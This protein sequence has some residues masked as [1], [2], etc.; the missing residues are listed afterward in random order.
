MFRLKLQN[1]IV[2]ENWGAPDLLSGNGSIKA[3]RELNNVMIEFWH[4]KKIWFGS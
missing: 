2:S 4:S 1:D 3:R